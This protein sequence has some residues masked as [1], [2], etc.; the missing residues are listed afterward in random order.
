MEE[1]QEDNKEKI[2]K[3]N[4]AQA[5]DDDE[6]D[7]YEIDPSDFIRKLTINSSTKDNDEVAIVAEKGPVALRDFPHPRHLCANFP[8]TTTPHETCCAKCFCYVCEIAAPC[9]QWTG[10]SAAHC[11]VTKKTPEE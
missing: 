7:C 8:F 1:E 3:I 9:L 2:A 5:E 10:T 4:K 11:D 6:D